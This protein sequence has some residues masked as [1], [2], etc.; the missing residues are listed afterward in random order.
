MSFSSAPAQ[1]VELLS[2]EMNPSARHKIY[3]RALALYQAML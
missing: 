3:Q 2:C 1:L